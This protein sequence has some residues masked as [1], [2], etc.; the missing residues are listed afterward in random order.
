M[1]KKV[2]TEKCPLSRSLIP[3]R[4]DM[5]QTKVICE[6]EFAEWTTDGMLRQPVF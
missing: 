2:V 3:I 4:R 5:G 1:L 6:G